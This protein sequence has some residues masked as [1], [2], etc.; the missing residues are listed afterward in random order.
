M[1]G[2]PKRQFQGGAC[3]CSRVRSFWLNSR[4]AVVRHGG[5]QKITS[6]RPGTGLPWR[7]A[8]A[9][10]FLSGN[11]ELTE[12]SPVYGTGGKGPHRIHAPEPGVISAVYVAEGD[13]VTAGQPLLTVATARF[14]GEEKSVETAVRQTLARQRERLERRI[15]AQEEVASREAARL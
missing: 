7:L 14:I 11:A 3:E 12:P 10:S 6:E 15:A 13:A 9:G 5:P 2:A 1:S 8:A 4:Q